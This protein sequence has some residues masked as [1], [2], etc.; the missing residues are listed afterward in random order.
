MYT[1][2]EQLPACRVSDENTELHTC[3]LN[4]VLP[5][6][7]AHKQQA[8]QQRNKAGMLPSIAI[9]FICTPPNVLENRLHACAHL[10]RLHRVQ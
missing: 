10:H 9:L 4:H 1:K 2:F 6:F 7:Q 5:T 8:A 3:I